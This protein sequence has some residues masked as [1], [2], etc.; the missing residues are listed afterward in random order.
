MLAS[1][2][3]TFGYL[4]FRLVGALFYNALVSRPGCYLP[5]FLRFLNIRYKAAR[6]LFYNAPTSLPNS[7]LFGSIFLA[8]YKFVIDFRL[9]EEVVE[10]YHCL[11]KSWNM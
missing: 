6:A 1:Q 7:P 8:I 5:T 2:E 9:Y 11:L 4:P 10:G 3:G